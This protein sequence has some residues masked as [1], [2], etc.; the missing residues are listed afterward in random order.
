MIKRP[1]AI[2]ILL[3]LVIL[4]ASLVPGQTGTAARVGQAISP[5][6]EVQN[7][8]ENLTP[9]EKVGQLFLVTFRGSEFDENSPILKL[10]SD[11]HVGGVV[12]Q[13]SN[14]NFVGPDQTVANTYR[15]I[16]ELQT[17]RFHELRW[18]SIRCNGWE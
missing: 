7:L 1:R 2:N 6:A 15:M 14:D 3:S 16:T 5:Q 8:L 9:E 12:L 11:Y 18:S 13:S 4:F 10:I 17:I